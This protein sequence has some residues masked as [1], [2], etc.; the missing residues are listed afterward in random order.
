VSATDLVLAVAAVYLGGYGLL[1]RRQRDRARRE[2]AALRRRL[3]LD[4]WLSARGLNR[5]RRP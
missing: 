5:S 1:V 2:L 4:L 3:G